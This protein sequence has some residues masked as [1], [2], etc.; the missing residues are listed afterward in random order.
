MKSDLLKKA[1]DIFLL[2]SDPRMTVGDVEDV[3]AEALEGIPLVIKGKIVGHFRDVHKV[4]YFVA[5]LEPSM[6][7]PEGL[8][9][10]LEAKG[11]TKVWVSWP[12]PEDKWPR[13]TSD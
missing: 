3:K 6:P 12:F 8:K 1:F 4:Q 11:S 2:P 7:L 13:G 9:R 5:S 10:K